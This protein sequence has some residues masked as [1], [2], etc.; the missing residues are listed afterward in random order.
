MSSFYIFFNTCIRDLCSFVSFIHFSCSPDWEYLKVSVIAMADMCSCLVGIFV[1][2]F[3]AEFF[4]VMYDLLKLRL[5]ALSVE[6]PLKLLVL[7]TLKRYTNDI[8]Y[9]DGMRKLFLFE[10][11]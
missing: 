2:Y 3:H 9:F 6:D 11:F 7:L 8:E 5:V 4:D 10:H 1:E